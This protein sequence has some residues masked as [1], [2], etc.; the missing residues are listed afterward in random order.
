MTGIRVSGAAVLIFLL[1]NFVP[2]L[3]VAQNQEILILKEEKPSPDESVIDQQTAPQNGGPRADTEGYEVFY[4]RWHAFEMAYAVGNTEKEIKLL[5]DMVSWRQYQNIP[6]LPEFSGSL[7]QMGD[8]EYAHKNFEEA[9]RLYEAATQMDPSY[10]PAFYAQAHLFFGMGI[11]KAIPG[12]RASIN[13]LFAPLQSPSGKIHFWSKYAL[14]FTVALLVAAFLFALILLVK[15][16]RLL[17]HDVIEKYAMK[18]RPASLNVL[19]WFLL[20]IPV[21]VLIGPLWLAAFWMMI[22]FGYSRAS[23]KL[24][25]LL[26]FLVFIA[27]YPVYLRTSHYSH[28]AYDA[29]VAPF[30]TVYSLG[31]SPKSIYDLQKYY[32]ENSQDAD[33]AILLAYLYKT[34]RAT[35]TAREILQ[36]YIVLHPGDARA[37]SNL[38]TI[39]FTRGE[40][41]SGLRFAQKA[42]DL[43]PRNP[44]YRYNLSKLQRAKFNF[45]EA[46]RELDQARKLDPALVQN[47][48]GSPQEK[49]ID[50]IPSYQLV[51]QRI[52]KKHGNFG[53][54][55]GNAF[56]IT[57]MIFFA[58]T[59]LFYWKRN[60][61]ARACDKCGKAFCKKCHS[62]AVKKYNYCSQCLHIFVKKDGVS[63]ISRKQKMHEIDK[64]HRRESIFARVSSLLLPGSGSLFQGRSLFGVL[65][66]TSWLFIVTILVFTYILG[67]LSY[68]EPPQTFAVIA[69]ICVFILALLYVVANV[70]NFRT[71]RS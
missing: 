15:Y 14:I 36:R 37:Y 50:A 2:S 34:D 20:F 25:I 5:Q 66:L 61:F 27:A 60:T 29:N 49:L 45:S 48:E 65:I 22:F 41:D 46:E 69:P 24:L 59:L 70:S 1:A 4:E 11:R 44:I 35:V 53:S 30:L 38:A 8:S 23:E 39:S 28:A 32:V 52:D 47:M 13:G 33:A 58:G 26:F 42:V 40:T 56:S 64:N 68:Y 57:A 18:V 31:A 55:F 43:D 21:L 3:L 54:L 19:I 10:S 12:I 9:L 51:W 6:G 16:N 63:P 7:V 67:P 62:S 17:R 71:V